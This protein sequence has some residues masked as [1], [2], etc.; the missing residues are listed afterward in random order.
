MCF[1]CVFSAFG[2][3]WVFCNIFK[4]VFPQ[5]HG[6][7]TI[8]RNRLALTDEDPAEYKTLKNMT[9][10]DKNCCTSFMCH[11]CDLEAIQQNDYCPQLPKHGTLISPIGYKYV[12]YQFCEVGTLSYS[13]EWL[14]C[15]LLMLQSTPF[16]HS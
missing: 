11:L 10:L 1:I 15:Q 7:I 4:Y 6:S 12:W 8:K 13:I 3:N 5:F 2:K 9:K 14:I 16:H